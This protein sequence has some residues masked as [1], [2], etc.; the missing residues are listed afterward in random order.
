MTPTE[1]Q[2]A[3]FNIRPLAEQFE[4]GVDCLYALCQRALRLRDENRRFREGPIADR[5]AAEIESIYSTKMRFLEAA[6]LA[7]KCTVRTFAWPKPTAYTC[8]TC[9]KSW[10]GGIG[11]CFK[12]DSL[13]KGTDEGRAPWWVYFF[14]ERRFLQPLASDAVQAIATPCVP[15]NPASTAA[16]DTIEA[17]YT[18]EAQQQILA[19]LAAKLAGES[20]RTK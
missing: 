11:K 8:A 15:M 16:R 5:R 9:G 10:H 12:C 4:I 19:I 17:P 20:A 14:G 7:G 2:L 3:D 18:I 13:A 1:R 6:A